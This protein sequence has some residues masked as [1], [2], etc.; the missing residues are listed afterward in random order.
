MPESKKRKRP[1]RTSR[2][3]R[4]GAGAQPVKK[5]GP[6]PRWLAPLMLALFGIGVLW[7]V[8]FYITQAR[9]GG[10]PGVSEIGN[11]NLLVG[12]GFIIAGFGL[13]TQWR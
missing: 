10:L 1:E 4:S 11:W 3:S 6:S 13:S 9:M 5:K 2:P 12:F 7:L 8:V